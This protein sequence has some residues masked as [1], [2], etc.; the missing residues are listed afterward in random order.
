MNFKLE[1]NG[2]K[3]N[4]SIVSTFQDEKTGINYVIY[5]DDELDSEKDKVIHAS[6]YEKQGEIYTIYPIESDYEWDLVDSYLDS[7]FKGEEM[8]E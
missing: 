4:C 6:R 2:K 3:I 1:Y 8:N 7:K 5:T